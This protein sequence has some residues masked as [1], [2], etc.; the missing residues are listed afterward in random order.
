MCCII[1]DHTIFNLR[2]LRIISYY[3]SAV[4]KEPFVFQ[5]YFG[6]NPKTPHTKEIN[7]S[8]LLILS[9]NWFLA[10]GCLHVQTCFSWII[11]Y[12]YFCGE[13]FPLLLLTKNHMR[14]HSCQ[15]R[16]LGLTIFLRLRSQKE[17]NYMWLQ[18]NT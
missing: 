7:N 13:I 3:I 4:Q 8:L 6:Q 18:T 11:V 14:R 2:K 12:Q 16:R 5:F 15:Y 9:V 1:Y 17:F 10:L